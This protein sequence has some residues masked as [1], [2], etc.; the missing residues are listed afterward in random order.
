M[1]NRT[2]AFPAYSPNSERHSAARSRRILRSAGENTSV[3]PTPT[4]APENSTAPAAAVV[5]T[6]RFAYSIPRRRTAGSSLDKSRPEPKSPMVEHSRPLPPSAFRSTV[7]S[8]TTSSSSVN[9]TTSAP[10]DFAKGRRFKWRSVRKGDSQIQK[11]TPIFMVR[12]TA[13]RK[14]F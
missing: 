2:P 11:F 13:A 3:P 5:S 6:E 1:Q 10:I 12:T 8:T 9:S 7:L 14:V 4:T